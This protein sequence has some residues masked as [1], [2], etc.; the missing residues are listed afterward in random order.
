MQPL[1][2]TQEMWVLY[3]R[4]TLLRSFR[5]LPKP[6]QLIV[7]VIVLHIGY[8]IRKICN[9]LCSSAS[10]ERLS[11]SP[12]R[13]WSPTSPCQVITT[14]II[15]CNALTH[16]VTSLLDYLGHTPLHE[17][18]RQNR[19]NIVALLLDAGADPNMRDLGC[20]TA[21]HVAAETGRSGPPHFAEL[22]AV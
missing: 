15:W 3:W 21:L 12:I 17:A 7:V 13:K 10:K 11:S 2:E 14:E 19:A 1:L 20:P 22:S 6:A 16:P 4:T 8:C 9:S 18:C 5:Y